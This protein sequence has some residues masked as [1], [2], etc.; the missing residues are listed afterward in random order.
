[1]KSYHPNNPILQRFACQTI[2][3]CRH[4]RTKQKIQSH[5]PLVDI[6]SLYRGYYRTRSL[7]GILKTWQVSKVIHRLH[8]VQFSDSKG[9]LSF[10]GRHQRIHKGPL[11]RSP[12]HFSRNTCVNLAVLLAGQLISGPQSPSH[13]P[14][15]SISSRAALASM[16]FALDLGVG[17]ENGPERGVRTIPSCFFRAWNVPAPILDWLV[18]IRSIEVE[19]SSWL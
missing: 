5:H 12:F 3:Q 8:Q 1:M 6:S 18:Q 15:Q 4:D 7:I 2:P 10:I 11:I 19:Y 13:P 17:F 14:R 16:A 9:T